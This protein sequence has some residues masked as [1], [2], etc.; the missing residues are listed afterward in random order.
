MAVSALL[1]DGAWTLARSRRATDQA[2]RLREQTHNLILTYRPHRFRV[3]A[4]GSDLSDADRR[5]IVR[6]FASQPTKS[7][8]GLS[9]GEV[10]ML[11]GQAIKPDTPEYEIEAPG[12]TMTLHIDCYKVFQPRRGPVPLSPARAS[13]PR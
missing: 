5:A 12:V 11:C 9:R 6:T 7:V 13:I 2:A 8:V 10:C 4:G 1:E 3:I